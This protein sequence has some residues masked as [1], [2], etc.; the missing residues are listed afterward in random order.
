MGRRQKHPEEEL[1]FVAL[2]D[3]MTNVV[4][5]LILVLVLIGLGL[6][7]SVSKVLSDLPI[8]TE[9]QHRSL[10]RELEE[11]KPK[12]KPEEVD[13]ETAK[14]REV[15]E[16][17]Q[18]QLQE[19]EKTKEKQNIQVIDF[20]ALRKQIAEKRKERDMRKA[21][22][23]QQLAEIDKLRARLDQTPV[24][25]APPATVVRLPNPRPMPEKAEVERF[26]VLGG[27]LYWLQWED[28]M[29]VSEEKLKANEVALSFSRESVKGPDGRP[30]MQR[31]KNGQMVPV[32]KVLY[33]SK[34]ISTFFT[35]NRV[36]NRDWR[37]EF[38]VSN[39]PQIPVRLMPQP[40]GGEALDLIKSAGSNFQRTLQQWKL[41][42]KKVVWFHVSGD[43][44]E[45]YLAAREVVDAIGV[46]AG[47]ELY[48]NPFWSLAM[49]SQYA[50]NY[51]PDPNPPQPQAAS[52]RP[53]IQ[54]APPKP[55]LD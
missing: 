55:T 16:K 49:P 42:S 11:N 22:T 20:E 12:E 40:G 53:V 46:P 7:K 47:W 33:D 28:L 30:A 26:L 24:Y 10:R 9:E 38:P 5:V 45:T 27:K 18:S 25:Q 41:D 14:L 21:A 32:R 4:G 52:G 6:A 8:V 43:S 23:E 44:I 48:G 51:I 19:A 36:F 1:P 31:N 2:M 37:L 35:E 34:K 17:L 29:R 15:V 3:T 50:L 13:K 54:I 39:T